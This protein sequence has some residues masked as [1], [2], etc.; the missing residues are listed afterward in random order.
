MKNTI[1]WIFL[2]AVETLFCQLP[3]TQI[4]II[5][6]QYDIAKSKFKFG[7]LERASKKKGYN[8]Q[9]AYAPDSRKFTM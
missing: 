2:L 8:N 6:M 9:P 4:Y 5:P 7:E 1:F 3:Q